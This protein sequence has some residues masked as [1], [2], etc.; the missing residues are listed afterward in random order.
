MCG[1]GQTYRQMFRSLLLYHSSRL[2]TRWK[3]KEWYISDLITF[4]AIGAFT[5]YVRS[6]CSFSTPSSPCQQF[7][8]GPNCLRP[9][10]EGYYHR[11]VHPWHN[12]FYRVSTTL[13]PWTPTLLRERAPSAINTWP[14][15]GVRSYSVPL[16]SVE[17]IKT[18]LVK[19]TPV[20]HVGLEFRVASWFWYHPLIWAI[21]SLLAWIFRAV[22]YV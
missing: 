3:G 19:C 15:Q 9:V 16:C 10:L 1:K 2:L 4:M 8:L 21:L 14:I 17:H 12:R 6:I 11:A 13:A 20:C 7:T 18:F 5:Y 22:Y